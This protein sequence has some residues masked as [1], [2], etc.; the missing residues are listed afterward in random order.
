MEFELIGK[1]AVAVLIPVVLGGMV[2]AFYAAQTRWEIRREREFWA[3]RN[4]YW[5]DGG[6]K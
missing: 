1:I 3:N 5:I 4:A 6:A 2:S